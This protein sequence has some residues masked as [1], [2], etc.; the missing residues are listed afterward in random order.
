MSDQLDFDFA[1]PG[2]GSPVPGSGLV[3]WRDE[4]RAA[5]E[6]LAAKQG[7]PLGQRVRVEFENGPPMEGLLLLDEEALFLPTKRDGHLAL[8]IGTG[9]FHADEIAACIRL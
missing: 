7:L 5:M 3:R 2:S 1:G 9:T 4:R 6:A 8:R